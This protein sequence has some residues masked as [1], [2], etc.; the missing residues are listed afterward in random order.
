[1]DTELA[2]AELRLGRDGAMWRS[3]CAVGLQAVSRRSAVVLWDRLET[4]FPLA[5]TGTTCALSALPIKSRH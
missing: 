1:M 5:R 2:A 3:R 4:A